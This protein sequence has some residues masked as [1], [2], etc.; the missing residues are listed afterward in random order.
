MRALRPARLVH[1]AFRFGVTPEAEAF[2]LARAGVGGFCLYGG[3]A[4]ATLE[5]TR[6]LRAAAPGPLLFSSDYEDGT[7][8]R[9][10]DGTRLPCNMAIAASGDPSLARRKGEITGAEARA[11][12]VEWALAPVA[13][14]ADEPQ[15]PIVSTRAFGSDPVRA[16]A[17]AAEYAAGLRSSGALSCAKQFPGHGGAREDSH[18]ELPS[19]SRTEE[20]MEADIGVFAEIL[21]AVDS[22]M[23]GHLLVPSLDPSAPASLAAPVISGLLRGRLAFRGCVVTDAL[24]MKAVA[25]DPSAGLRAFL[26]GADVLLAPEDP[27]ALIAA[28]EEAVSSGR[29]EACALAAAL[30]RQD[31]LVRRAAAAAPPDLSVIGCA[32][33]AA[34]AEEAAPRCLARAFGGWSR[35]APGEPVAVLELGAA[36]PGPAGGNRGTLRPS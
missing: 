7:G 13:D 17:M 23:A 4:A 2:R 6:A 24:E 32:A 29:I 16:A 27:S 19:L 22:V 18:L 9:L 36:G 12:G 8:Q 20:R 11:A 34:F 15:N 28:L 21:G 1:P 31:E 30:A 25:A 26:A 14:L 3:G 33:H 5:L 10:S 35:P